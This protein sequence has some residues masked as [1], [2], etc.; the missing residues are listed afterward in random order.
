MQGV[1]TQTGTSYL[2]PCVI[3]T[4]G[5]YLRGRIILGDTSY[6][7]GPNGLRP[8]LALTQS[9]LDV[10][11]RMGR[12]KTGTPPRVSSRSVDFGA[13]QEQLGDELVRGFAGPSSCYGRQ[14][15]CWLTYT[16]LDT[17][18]IFLDNLHRAPLYSG[19]I[20]A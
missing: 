16:N 20:E 7:S 13:M 10:G 4:T 6:S 3:L 8:A 18:R 14:L 17:H 15:S 12:F 2:A 1:V 9:M 5:T 19:E 11:I